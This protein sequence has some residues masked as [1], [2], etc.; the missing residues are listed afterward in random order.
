MEFSRKSLENLGERLNA[1]PEQFLKKVIFIFSVRW[2]LLLK[3]G[4]VPQKFFFHFLQKCFFSRK[5][6]QIFKKSIKIENYD[7]LKFLAII[8]KIELVDKNWSNQFF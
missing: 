6:L 4:H 5:N 8:D 2:P 1:P 3:N 7:K